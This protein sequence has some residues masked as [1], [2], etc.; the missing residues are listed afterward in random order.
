MVCP[1]CG[2]ALSAN[3]ARC[4]CGSLAEPTVLTGVVPFDATGLPHGVNFGA[5]TGLTGVTRLE[6]DASRASP[7][8]D[9]PTAP[10]GDRTAATIGDAGT[11]G[12]QSNIADA[13]TVAGQTRSARDAGPLKIGQS[14]GPRYHI[15]KLLGAGGMGAVYQAWDTELGVAVAL[16]VIRGR[17]VSLEQQKRFKNELLLARSVTHKNVVRIHDLGEIDG[18]KFI[19]MSYVRGDDLAT[20]L[21]TERKF[22][23]DRALGLARQIAAGLQ[24]AHDAGVVHR[25]LKP[26]N[27]MIGADDL[28]LIMD[29]GI[30][31]SADEVSSG[32]I[33]GTLEY[34]APEQGAGQ[35]TDGRADIYAF[36]LILYEMLV[37]PR[38]SAATT[39][40]ER[41]DAMRRRSKDGIPEPRSI[42]SSV[43]EAVNS[44]VMRCLEI[45]PAAR[46]QST[47]E[48]S[49]ALARVDDAGELIPELTRISKR[50]L[51]AALVLVVA[52]IGATYF[53]GRRAA[54]PALQHAA[55]GVVIADFDNRTGDPVFNGSVE[56]ALTVGVEG[57]P[58]ITAM[59]SRDAHR[60]AAQIGSGKLDEA[61][62]TLVAVRE[63]VKFVVGGTIEAGGRGY[64]VI[65]RLIDPAVGKV[66]KTSS[67]H[68]RSKRRC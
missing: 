28:A 3:G 47:T 5:S 62:A 53:V 14:F 67:A 61:A 68:A 52:L 39:V 15:I 13:A 41:I 60:V 55:V 30:S 48:L 43:P 66:T 54:A 58:F 44:L 21:R 56:Q 37:G 17:T 31:A 12:G 22:P 40:Q 16:K 32:G 35:T 10:H 18:K 34:M 38:G 42:D 1:R 2:E 26:A 7:F 4:R 24:A 9:S 33:V 11:L 46:F 51:A 45:D 6:P 50:L 63:G 65:A 19:T 25:D 20:L 36:G 64:R 49:A 29:F 27:I 59:P 8:G 57:A 23:V